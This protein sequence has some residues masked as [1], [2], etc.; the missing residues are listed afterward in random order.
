MKIFK[1]Y[2]NNIR[3]YCY[4]KIQAH[5]AGTPE[6]YTRMLKTLKPNS[7]ILEIGI[8]N[9]ICIEKNA[10]QIKAGNFKIVGIDIDQGYLDICQKRIIENN[11]SDYVS[12]YYLDLL[13][14]HNFDKYDYIVFPGSYPV[15]PL[16]TMYRMLNKSKD[17][18]M[19][20]NGEIIFIHSLYTK[21]EKNSLVMI[22]ILDFIKRNLKYIPLVWTDFGRMTNVFEFE[23][24]INTQGF[25]IKEKIPLGFASKKDSFPKEIFFQMIGLTFKNEHYIYKLVFR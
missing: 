6:L 3:S 12:C 24:V 5:S 17:L 21:N 19:D 22:G 18:I 8:G 14:T 20:G 16:K 4:D 25:S 15:I 23:E 7:S 1:K 10:N 2:K 11:L 13:S 9:G